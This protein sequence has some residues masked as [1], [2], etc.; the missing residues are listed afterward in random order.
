MFIFDLRNHVNMC[1][2]FVRTLGL[3]QPDKMFN[4]EM[5]D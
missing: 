2:K 5:F 4:L 1:V 3:R